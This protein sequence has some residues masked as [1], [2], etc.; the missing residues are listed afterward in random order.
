M[1]TKEEREQLSPSQSRL[2]RDGSIYRSRRTHHSTHQHHNRNCRLLHRTEPSGFGKFNIGDS[3]I[4]G[5]II[6]TNYSSMWQE[7]SSSASSSASRY[8]GYPYGNKFP[9][10]FPFQCYTYLRNSKSYSKHVLLPLITLR[11]MTG[12]I[13]GLKRRDD[14]LFIWMRLVPALVP[15]F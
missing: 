1:V 9:Q 8:H 6:C 12:Y 3:N 10:C 11:F 7:A 14:N 4:R 2:D 15:G 13:S 5:P